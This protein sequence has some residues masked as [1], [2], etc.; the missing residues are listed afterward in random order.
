LEPVFATILEKAVRIC[1]ATFGNIYRFDG[2]FF[3]L[4]AT[5]NTP[6]AYAEKRRQCPYRPHPN[7]DIG[8]MVVDKTV[9]HIADVMAEEVYTAQLDPVAVDAVNIGGIRTILGVPF[10][11]QRRDVRHI[12]LVSSRSSS[13]HR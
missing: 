7:S 11:D 1:D 10:D 12:L 5:H 3:H 9:A 6:P 2:E 13:V 8:R 4:V